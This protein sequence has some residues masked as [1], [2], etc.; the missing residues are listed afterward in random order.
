MGSLLHLR[1]LILILLIKFI[2][3]F[4]FNLRRS[5]MMQHRHSHS[6]LIYF[7]FFIPSFHLQPFHHMIVCYFT[8]YCVCAKLRNRSIYKPVSESNDCMQCKSMHQQSFDSNFSRLWISLLWLWLLL[9]CWRL[10]LDRVVFRL[11][12]ASS[13]SAS[14]FQIY[15]KLS[16]NIC[17]VPWTRTKP[18]PSSNTSNQQ[19]P[20]SNPSNQ[21]TLHSEY[22]TK[23]R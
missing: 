23:T 6:L 13:W 12:K 22:E 19:Q 17:F 9:L 3:I 1:I 8:Y 15:F 14:V 18:K 11:L 7:F 2:Q 16:G 5:A 21:Q 4:S 20:P 10:L